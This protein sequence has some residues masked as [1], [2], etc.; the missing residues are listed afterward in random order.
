MRIRIRVLSHFSSAL[1]FDESSF[2]IGEGITFAELRSKLIEQFSAF[3]RP[4]EIGMY[5]N[6]KPVPDD[7][8]M[9]DGDIVYV[10][11]RSSTP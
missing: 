6:M 11:P 3:V 10:F 1:G 8:T 2:S 4:I 7:Y 9:M 5:V